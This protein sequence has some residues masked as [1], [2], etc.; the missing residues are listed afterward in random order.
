[1]RVSGSLG[2]QPSPLPLPVTHPCSLLLSSCQGEPGGAG[3]PGDPGEDVSRECEGELME[4]HP[5]PVP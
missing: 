2:L 5:Y 3:E 1:M 4:S